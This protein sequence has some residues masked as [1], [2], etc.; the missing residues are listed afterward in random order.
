MSPADTIVAVSSGWGHS[1]WALVRMSGPA[2]R[3]RLAALVRTGDDTDP[4]GRAAQAGSQDAWT[5]R[6]AKFLLTDRHLLPCLVMTFDPPRTFTGEPMAELLVPGNPLIIN[7]VLARLSEGPGVR[8]AEPG[9]FSA[10]AFLRGKL[11]LAQAE[12]L[13][14]SIAAD[15][16]SQLAAAARLRSGA[17]GALHLGWCDELA[18]LLALVEA[19]IDFTDQ[20]DVVP[21]GP[22]ALAAR[23]AGLRQQL[24]DA[25]GGRRGE[26]Q[27]RHLPRVALVGPPNAGK[28]TLFNAL[29]GRRRAV[30]SPV[31]GTTRDV[32]AEPLTL[33]R[34]DLV[35]E[36]LDL[37][38]LDAALTAD[39][40]IDRDA[41]EHARR[42]IDDADIVVE[43]LPVTLSAADA[44]A[45][46]PPAPAGPTRPTIR[47][48]TMADLPY[49][50]DAADAGTVAVCALDGWNLE[51]LR[52][53]IADAAYQPLEEQPGADARV[54][55]VPRHRRTLARAV[56]GLRAAEELIDAEAR[57]LG[58]PEVIA[59]ELR[60]ALDALAELTGQISPDDIIGRIFA[61][62]CI[63]K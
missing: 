5:I 61:T 12:G 8:D 4:N 33:D 39:S 56:A 9:E 37:P 28:S 15:T 47:V 50:A 59:G 55:L 26:E 52:R 35:V 53:A 58:N 49:A 60:L 42:A 32:I 34:A 19:G 57:A 54:A 6:P 14:A 41:Q 62:F 51:V 38:G 46:V 7:R 11:T 16:E 17:S 22:A 10:R 23:V 20:E 24:T 48:R 1:R 29:L 18:E 13:A 36:L 44:R 2:T 27:A 43:C 30:E 3:E 63:G 45:W 40:A 25:L 31:A 21:I